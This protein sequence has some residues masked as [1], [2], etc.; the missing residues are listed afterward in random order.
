MRRGSFDRVAWI[1]D[2]L[3]RLVF[4]NAVDKSQEAL[5]RHLPESGNLLLLGGGTG[6][7]LPELWRLRPALSITFIDASHEMIRR[8]KAR[9]APGQKVQFIHGTERDI[10][11]GMYDSILTPFYLDMFEGEVLDE[12]LNV[13][14][15]HVVQN[16]TWLV[17]DFN[18]SGRW[19]Q[20]IMLNSMYLF[21]RWTTGIQAAHLADL[22]TALNKLGWRESDQATYYR[23]FIKA[24]FFVR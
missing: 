10:P 2:T 15:S 21:F 23:G 14:S 8:A 18:D 4:G 13:L 3:A 12:I 17:A 22:E 20:A 16:G 7:F 24:S 1:Y 19:W 9:Q 11:S 6:R 5:L